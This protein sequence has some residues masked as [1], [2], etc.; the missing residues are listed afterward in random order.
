MTMLRR[1]I[2]QKSIGYAFIANGIHVYLHENNVDLYVTRLVCHDCGA[3]WYMNITECYV[4][5]IINPYLYQCLD[6]SKFT[7]ITNAA[8]KC[9]DCNS[10][11]IV[12]ACVNA[13]CITNQV[14]ELKDQINSFGGV[15][16]KN[17]GFSIAQQ[18]CM[19]CGSNFHHY[20]SYS[21]KI[22]YTEDQIQDV[23]EIINSNID[24]DLILI[25]E[26]LNN[27]L[28]YHLYK[29]NEVQELSHLEFTKFNEIISFLFPIID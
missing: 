11:N 26:K 16:N 21:I 15:F 8:K 23:E 5:G 13:D 4:C 6:C 9:K 1:K 3:P 25:K 7:S 14:E 10:N 29:I 28:K 27:S 17:S 19:H 2:D 22:F 12:L 18:Y 20:R 24:N